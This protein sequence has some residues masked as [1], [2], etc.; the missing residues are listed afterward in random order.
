MPT[1]RYTFL[2]KEFAKVWNYL[3]MMEEEKRECKEEKRKVTST[4]SLLRKEKGMVS[5]V[6]FIFWC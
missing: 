1:H 5:P 6:V 4:T 2:F 3:Q